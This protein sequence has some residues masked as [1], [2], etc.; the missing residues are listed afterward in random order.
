MIEY[1][2]FSVEN[3][4]EVKEIYAEEGWNAYLKD[5]GNLSRAFGNSMFILGAFDGERLIGFIRCLGD[6]EHL[7]IVQ[8]LI[9]RKEYQRWIMRFTE[10]WE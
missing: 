8:D 9:I 10:R 7:V 6:G 5:D 2:E 3:L 1:K 4:E